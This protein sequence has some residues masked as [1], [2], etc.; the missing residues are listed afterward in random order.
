MLDKQMNRKE[1]DNIRHDDDNH[2]AQS[3]F[4]TVS[5]KKTRRA[6]LWV[7][8]GWQCV[9]VLLALINVFSEL[10][11]EQLINYIYCKSSVVLTK[12]IN[13]IQLSVIGGHRL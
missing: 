3:M 2:D 8:L 4:N 10:L 9:A 11:T 12:F 13:Y 6:V 5:K 7:V 1:N